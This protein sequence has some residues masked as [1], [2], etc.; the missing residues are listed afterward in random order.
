[1]ERGLSLHVISL[2]LRVPKVTI[3]VDLYNFLSFFILM[4]VV[5]DGYRGYI[6]FGDPP[7]LLKHAL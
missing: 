6:L 3:G 1:M 5:V 4:K 7:E 2:R